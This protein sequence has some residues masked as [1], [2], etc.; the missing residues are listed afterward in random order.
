MSIN[1]LR[2]TAIATAALVGA[3]ILLG[4]CSQTASRQLDPHKLNVV[5]SFYPLYD[6][7]TKIGGD[8]V[9]AVNLVPAGVEPHDWS[10]KSRDLQLLGQAQVF[11]YEGI[12]FE[13]WVDNA[14][15]TLKTGG[16]VVV[17][18]GKGVPL[19]QATED[20]GHDVKNTDGHA[21]EMPGADPHIWLS[22]A[23]AKIIGENLKQAFIQADPAHK[24][25]YEANYSSFAAKLDALDG[26]Y[27]QQLSA[28]KQ[29]RLVVSHQAFGYLC[30]DY[31]LE[32]MPIMGLAP[33]A[34]PTAQEM[35]K[36]N[37]FIKQNNVKTIFFEELVSD[38]L[39]KT[40]AKDAGVGTMVL[41]PLEGLTEEQQKAGQDYFTVMETNLQHLVQALQ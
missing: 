39:A 40:L 26:K 33:D 10:P 11:A 4:G 34:E 37:D 23:N 38:K 7:A 3:A 31:G 25:D 17:E 28:V 2:F 24:Q 20:D 41:N 30:R 13:G 12:G 27:K 18:A 19:L 15:K 8:H 6:F 22:P 1:K 5:A 16:P 35:K 32:Q 29:K 21:A 14:L 36:I 9:H